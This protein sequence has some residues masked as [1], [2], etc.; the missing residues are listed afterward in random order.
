MSTRVIISNRFV[1]ITQQ[2]RQPLINNN[3]LGGRTTSTACS[4]NSDAYRKTSINRA[5]K[6]IRRLLECNFPDDYAFITFT[7]GNQDDFDTTN[8]DTC[9]KL[10]SDFKKRLVYYLNK[11]GL[12]H[13]KY[14]GVTEFQDNRGGTVHYHLICNLTGIPK[15]HL[16]ELWGY[17]TVHIDIVDSKPLDNEKISYYLKK[18]IDDPRLSGKKKYLRSKCLLRPIKLEVFDLSSLRDILESSGSI[19]L[20]QETYNS[21]LFGDVRYETFYT[22][23]TEELMK[24]AEEIK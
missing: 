13:L 24:Y 17:G 10:F 15:S 1:E 4:D 6:N 12:P 18:G 8:V 2:S 19:P 7:F 5:R 21:P 11:Y 14:L 3:S 9:N 22:L 20:S 23:N 16:E